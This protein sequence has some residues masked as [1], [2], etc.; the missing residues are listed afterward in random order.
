MAFDWW[1]FG[2]EAVNF[3]VLVLLLRHFFFRP[4]AAAIDTRRETVARILA[5]AQAAREAAERARREAEAEHARQ[6]AERARFIEAA[7][8]AAQE[9]AE[10]ILAH[11]RA[12]AERLLEEARAEARRLR[13]NEAARM[14][15]EAAA[16]AADIAAGVLSGLPPEMQIEPFIPG[17][18]EGLASLVGL[19][20]GN[21]RRAAGARGENGA[22]ATPPPQAGQ[23]G[24][25]SGTEAAGPSAPPLVVTAPR[26]LSER[27]LTVLRSALEGVLGR[28]PEIEVEVD[29]RVIAGLE[30]AGQFGIVRNS[31]RASLERI[32]EALVSEAATDG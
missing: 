31:L 10:E 19:P 13:A 2:L 11:A 3:L 8:R 7:E 9:R 6:V 30:L 12:E 27:E 16:L 32:R 17:L 24:T 28:A 14:R 15:R 5:E 23:A 29:P 20:D 4:V 25:D 1:S 21:G 26:A 18:V 22:E